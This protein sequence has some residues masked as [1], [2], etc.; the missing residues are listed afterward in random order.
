[1]G[2]MVTIS[3][4]Q[5]NLQK[6]RYLEGLEFEPS[7]NTKKLFYRPGEPAC[8]FDIVPRLTDWLHKRGIRLRLDTNGRA[9]LMYPGRS[10]V[11]GLKA[12]GLNA[13]SEE[14]YHPVVQTRF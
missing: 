13:E 3:A 9:A 7:L 5:G 6:K 4:I 10:I 1:M 8:R 2:F 11:A 12:A 14:K